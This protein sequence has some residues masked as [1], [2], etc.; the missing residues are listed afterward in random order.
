MFKN[1][2]QLEGSR[3][4]GDQIDARNLRR[5]YVDASLRI[6]ALGKVANAV[7]IHFNLV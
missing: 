3:S 1:A 2:H 7:L 6:D 5:G 4:L